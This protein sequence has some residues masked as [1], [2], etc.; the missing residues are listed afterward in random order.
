MEIEIFKKFVQKRRRKMTA[1][2]SF[3]QQCLLVGCLLV[4]LITGL[5]VGYLWGRS[6]HK[7]GEGK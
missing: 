6:S 5:I 7:K 1:I 4:M 3:G 2:L